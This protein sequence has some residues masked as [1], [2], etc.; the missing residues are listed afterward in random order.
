MKA[1]GIL[2]RYAIMWMTVIWLLL[3]IYAGR[4]VANAYD[5]YAYELVE[6]NDNALCAHMLE[7]YRTRFVK[8]WLAP[9]LKELYSSEELAQFDLKNDVVSWLLRNSRFSVYPSSPEFEAVGW[10]VERRYGRPYKGKTAYYP[11]LTAELDIDNDGTMEFLFKSGFFS[12]QRYAWESILV[13]REKPERPKDGIWDMS[14]V[15]K[16]RRETPG[17]RKISVH[18]IVRPFV[19][20]SRSYLSIYVYGRYPFTEPHEMLIQQYGKGEPP[21][22]LTVQWIPGKT[23]CKYVMTATNRP[24]RK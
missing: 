5:E 18:G 3:M 11:V 4:S 12:A 21:T 23:L 20:N 6:N 7:V 19:F 14:E 13:F 8:P 17:N 1:N 16:K 10:T 9:P 2:S 24:L 15:H 22:P